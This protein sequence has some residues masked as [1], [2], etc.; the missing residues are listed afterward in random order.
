MQVRGLFALLG[1]IGDCAHKQVVMEVKGQA[2]AG[3]LPGMGATVNC[4]GTGSG[5]HPLC[6]LLERL[7]S[8]NLEPAVVSLRTISSLNPRR[9]NLAS[10]FLYP[11]L[12][13][14]FIADS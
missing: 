11:K 2:R 8:L 9:Q 3:F 13:I 6:L 12:R 10:T 14:E 5:H 4:A 7:S 1:G